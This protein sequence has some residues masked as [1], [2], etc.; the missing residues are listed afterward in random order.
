MNEKKIIQI[1]LFL[2]AVLVTISSLYFYKIENFRKNKTFDK[3]KNKNNLVLS[4]DKLNLIKDI[5]YFSKDAS[6]NQFQIN[7]SSG[8][9]NIDNT[10][11]INMELVI[12]KIIF[13]NSG[14]IYITSDKAKYNNQTYETNFY[15]NVKVIYLEHQI[16]S[17]NLHLFLQNNTISMTNNVVYKSPN[18]S[19]E[20]DIIEI[21]ILVKK[22]NIFM[23]DKSKKIKALYN[24]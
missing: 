13:L 21:D 16:T 12:A 4:E 22:L 24:N 17:D 18:S 23:N 8:S 10:N 9:T 7:S 3:I 6:G 20:A 5:S 19:I 14:T 15:E 2:L 1:S 11:I